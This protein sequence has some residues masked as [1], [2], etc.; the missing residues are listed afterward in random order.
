MLALTT[1]A[2]AQS[3]PDMHAT[4]DEP[5]TSS[6]S[7][8]YYPASGLALRSQL[9]PYA[10][11]EGQ[12]GSDIWGYT[13]ASS[14]REYALMT[15]KT[16]MAVVDVT[17]PQSAAVVGRVSSPSSVWKDVKTYGTYAYLVTDDAPTAPEILVVDLS[18]LA[19]GSVTVA[20]TITGSAGSSSTHNVAID[21]TSGFL[22]R[23]GGVGGSSDGMRVYSLANPR[24]PSY[25][26]TVGSDF[27]HDAHVVTFTSGT[28][29]GKQIAFACKA[30][31][32]HGLQI[33]DV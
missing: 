22:Y 8:D 5:L 12:Y 11:C 13:D 10:C 16:G 9:D 29:A 1:L 7:N 3:A 4:S 21:T 23:L 26:A 25:V 31:S 30:Q 15:Y 28:Y 6:S 14:G 24:A 27:V 20:A 19:T 2:V 18:A 32:P 17:N 33:W